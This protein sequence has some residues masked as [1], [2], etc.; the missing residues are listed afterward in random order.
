M[1]LDDHQLKATHDI[2]NFLRAA[3]QC[4]GD[5]ARLLRAS[6]L[7]YPSQLH[8]DNIPDADRLHDYI[9]G[10]DELLMDG[11]RMCFRLANSAADVEF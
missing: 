10:L 5:A 6:D 4:A 3:Q 11:I 9:I 2:A 1:L 7:I 8:I